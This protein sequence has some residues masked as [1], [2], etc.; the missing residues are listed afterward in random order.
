MKLLTLFPTD[1][2]VQEINI[3]PLDDIILKMSV[4]EPS[5]KVTNMGGWQSNDALHE[6]TAFSKLVD[7]VSICFLSIG[8]KYR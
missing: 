2:Y 7:A 3:I 5:R 1:V 6:H 8:E 4:T